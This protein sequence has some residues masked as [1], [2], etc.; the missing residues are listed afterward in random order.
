MASKSVKLP[1]EVLEFLD[2]S[3]FKRERSV[4]I[5]VVMDLLR[6]ATISQGKAAELLDVNRWDLIELMASHG[7]DAVSYDPGELARDT[8]TLKNALEPNL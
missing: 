8:A 4:M 1:E 5:A 3:D 6:T 2:A 7:V